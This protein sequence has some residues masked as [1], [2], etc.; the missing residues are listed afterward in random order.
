MIDRYE[1]EYTLRKDYYQLRRDRSVFKHLY[2]YFG[3][4]CT[5]KE[6]ELKIGGYEQF[7]M[8]VDKPAKPSTVVKEL[9]VLRRMFNVARKQWKWKIGNPVSDIELPKVRN[10]RVRYLTD[11]ER[12]RLFEALVSCPQ[13]LRFCVVVGLGTGL[14]LSNICNLKW[15]EVN[16]PG[17]IITISAQK[18]KNSDYLGIPIIDSVLEVLR[19]AQ[20]VK[21]ISGHVIH[22]G[23]EPL[24]YV[25]VQRAFKELLKAAAIENFRF[26]DLRHSF[27]SYLRQQ[28]VDLHTIAVLAGHRDVRMTKRYSHLHVESLRQAVQTLEGF[29][30]N[31]AQSA[32]TKDARAV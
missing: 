13:W 23:G 19:E 3:R 8:R 26:H 5:L 22:D 32:G 7:R 20:K 31:L 21:A 25:K 4:E 1:Q 27:C 2:L 15:E 12:Q 14:R 30:T 16:L 24:Y 29:I 17:Q 10:E 18:M 6:I 9:G 11:D 28:G